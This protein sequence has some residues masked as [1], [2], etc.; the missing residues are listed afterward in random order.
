MQEL[1]STLSYFPPEQIFVG[2]RVFQPPVF[3]V[4]YDSRHESLPT[5]QLPRQTRYSWGS[6]HLY[7]KKEPPSQPLNPK[8]GHLPVFLRQYSRTHPSLPTGNPHVFPTRQATYSTVA[9]QSP[10]Q[11][12]GASRKQPC[13]PMPA[14]PTKSF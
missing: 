8:P 5:S 4:R 1:L 2:I 7:L 10:L 11:T 3:V 13:L 14:L 9:C 6:G 12:S